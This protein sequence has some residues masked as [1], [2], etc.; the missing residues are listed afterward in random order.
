MKRLLY[1]VLTCTLA[2]SLMPSASFAADKNDTK[3]AAAA[4]AAENGNVAQRFFVAATSDIVTGTIEEINEAGMKVAAEGGKLYYVP[5]EEFR[6][7]EGF[8]ALELKVGTAVSL[9][10]PQSTKPFTMRLETPKEDNGSFTV[11]VL[12]ALEASEGIVTA[13][14]PLSISISA[15]DKVITDSEG[16]VPAGEA[17]TV[18][19]AE[20]VAGRIGEPAEKLSIAV[21][22]TIYLHSMDLSKITVVFPAGEISANGKTLSVQEK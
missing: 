12:P 14:A 16:I 19:K 17:V 18:V 8:A 3:T 2:L 4:V 7:Q 15:S 11:S 1:G 10:S 6:S 21:S 13:S 22:D 20:K 9:K 5:L